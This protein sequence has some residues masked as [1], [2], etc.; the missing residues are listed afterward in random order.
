MFLFIRKPESFSQNISKITK[1]MLGGGGGG[2]GW[3]FM[4]GLSNSFLG[5]GCGM[6]REGE[7]AG[8][9]EDTEAN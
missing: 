9:Q 2:G 1:N 6:G 8:T 5:G 3:S 4:G 7:V